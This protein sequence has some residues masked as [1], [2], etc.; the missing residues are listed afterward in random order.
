[1]LWTR[2]GRGRWPSCPPPDTQL[3]VGVERMLRVAFLDR[4][5]L[6]PVL[7]V[8]LGVGSSAGRA[9]V[10]VQVA[11]GGVSPSQAELLRARLRDVA[12]AVG[13]PSGLRLAVQAVEKAL[14]S[15]EGC[16]AALLVESGLTAKPVHY[17]VLSTLCRLWRLPPTTWTATSRTNSLRTLLCRSDGRQERTALDLVAADARAAGVL[18]LG[19]A[20]DMLND[21]AVPADAAPDLLEAWELHRQGS[22]VVFDR[23]RSGRMLR[24]VQRLLAVTGPVGVRVVL[25][26]LRRMRSAA[27]SPDPLPTEELL[28]AWAREHSA[29]EVA[30]GKIGLTGSDYSAA[31]TPADRVV[32][33]VLDRHAGVAPVAEIKAALV[34]SGRST[35]L[36]AAQTLLI[37]PYL[38]AAGRGFVRQAS[39]K[40]ERLQQLPKREGAATPT[41]ETGSAAPSRGDPG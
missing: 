14:P 37:A 27:Y 3:D 10:S 22:P 4:P 1:M 11:T 39:D 9:P 24:P 15:S 5:E 34:A 12:H 20:I 25:D 41:E 35:S 23:R 6:L 19:R 17:G 30:A 26:G 18:P 33:S 36:D 7:H 21:R 29:F 40:P 2:S 32:V 31:M 13:P 16:L 8:H 38:R 28:L